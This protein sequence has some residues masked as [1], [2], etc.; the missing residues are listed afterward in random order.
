MVRN[1]FGTPTLVFA[2]CRIFRARDK[3][4]VSRDGALVSVQQSLTGA[5]S[6]AMQALRA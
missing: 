5:L 3:W 4:V 1:V 6:R 2:G